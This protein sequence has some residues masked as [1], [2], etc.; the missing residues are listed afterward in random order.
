MQL[1]KEK[2]FFFL[3][4]TVSIKMPEHT[5][6]GFGRSLFHAAVLCWMLWGKWL[7]SWMSEEA[8]NP[9]VCAYDFE[10]NFFLLNCKI[11]QLVYGKW[12]GL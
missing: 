12:S 4:Q 7:W 2:K 6:L 8:G 9:I 10:Q 1:E 3:H 11:C 5:K